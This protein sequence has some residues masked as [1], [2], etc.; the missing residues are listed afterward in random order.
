MGGMVLVVVF[1]P[2]EEGFFPS[3]TSLWPIESRA[4]DDDRCLYFYSRLYAKICS[5]SVS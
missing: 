5:V 4:D 3:I 2:Q 1:N